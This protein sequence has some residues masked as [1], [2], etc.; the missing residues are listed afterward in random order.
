MRFK[1]EKLRFSELS[2]ELATQVHEMRLNWLVEGKYA[3]TSQIK[4]ATDST[5]LNFAE[6]TVRQS[7]KRFNRF[8]RIAISSEV[9]VVN[10]FT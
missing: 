4:R 7:D 10:C 5:S 8:F 2:I 1:F 9:E 3:L 6:G